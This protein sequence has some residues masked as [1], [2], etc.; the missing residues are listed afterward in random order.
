MPNTSSD[1]V[2]CRVVVSLTP[3]HQ[4]DTVNESTDRVV[5]SAAIRCSAAASGGELL[6]SSQAESAGSGHTAVR[7]IDVQS[8]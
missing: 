4:M 1:E 3:A 7:R 8:G 5:T 2:L 6:V